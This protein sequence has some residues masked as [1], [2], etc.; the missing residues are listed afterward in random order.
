MTAHRC[1][2]CG[3]ELS[4][5]TSVEAGIGPVCRGRRAHEQDAER[6]R[7]DEN[8]RC[9]H[10][11]VCSNPAHAGTTIWRFHHRFGLVAQSGI[12][13]PVHRQVGLLVTEFLD[14]LGLDRSHVPVPTIDVPLFGPE[15]ITA[16]GLLAR[17]SPFG[18][19]CCE[20]PVDHDEQYRHIKLREMQVCPFGLDCCDPERAVAIIWQ[21]LSL[22]RYEVEPALL[23]A[24][25]CEWSWEPPLYQALA[26]TLELL[27][28]HDDAQEVEDIVREQRHQPARLRLALEEA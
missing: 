2:R 3:R 24:D 27:G 10:G 20:M 23:T 11:F 25:S 15:T 5:H 6:R 14:V 19:T 26:N 9:H 4:N 13:L 21:L 17:P 18:G 12:P 22:M 7:R 1:F 8:L 16:L 28:L